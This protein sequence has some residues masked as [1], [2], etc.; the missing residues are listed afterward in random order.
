MLKLTYDHGDF[1]FVEQTPVM[2]L[3]LDATDG[4]GVSLELYADKPC[5]I[6]LKGPDGDALQL[7]EGTT[8]KQAFSTVGFFSLEVRCTPSTKYAIRVFVLDNLDSEMNSGEPAVLQPVQDYDQKIDLAVQKR[9][10]KE[11]AATGFAMEDIQE[12]ITGL[13]EDDTLEFDDEEDLPSEAEMLDIIET[14]RAEAQRRST[15]SEGDETPRIEEPQ[16]GPQGDPDE[17]STDS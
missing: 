3:E 13:N 15:Q 9:L 14:A 8:I 2:E 16:D 12:L 10:I 17:Q 7:A 6:V 4:S 1:Q 5:R 11:L